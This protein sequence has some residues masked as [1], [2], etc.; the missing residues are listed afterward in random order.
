MMLHFLESVILLLLM[1]C[2]LHLMKERKDWIFGL[3]IDRLDGHRA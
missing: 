3:K 1:G 2:M